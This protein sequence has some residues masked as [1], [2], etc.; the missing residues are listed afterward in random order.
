M[1]IL[2][3]NVISEPTKLDA[4][5]RVLE[6][7]DEQ[8]AQNLYITSVSLAELLIG[9]ELL[10]AGRRRVR[11]EARL[12]GLLLRLFG[13]QVLSFDEPAARMYALL[14]GL[15]DGQI[16]SIAAVR[17]YSV[18]TRDVTPFEAM[19]LDVINPWTSA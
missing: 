3:T 6:W 8:D 1:I 9:M 10:P 15:A 19:G 18:A 13:S 11:L 5:T 4:N 16:G 7:L 12:N 14:A 17:G 2:D